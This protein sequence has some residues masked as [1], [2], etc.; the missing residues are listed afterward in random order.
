LLRVAAYHP[1]FEFSS[2]VPGVEKADKLVDRLV[3]NCVA[4]KTRNFRIQ[5]KSPASVAFNVPV[6]SEHT[7]PGKLSLA[8]TILETKT[9]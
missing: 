5:Q 1:Q 7:L 9:D 2:A 4:Q 8:R 3:W 6:G